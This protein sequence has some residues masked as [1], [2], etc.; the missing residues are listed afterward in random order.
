M[1]LELMVGGK[2]VELGVLGW[3]RSIQVQEKRR[4]VLLGVEDTSIP[5]LDKVVDR[6]VPEPDLAW[7]PA[8]NRALD[9]IHWATGKDSIRKIILAVAQRIQEG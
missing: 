6:F 7:A 8:W 3:L 9:A 2:A 4:T 1:V 5:V